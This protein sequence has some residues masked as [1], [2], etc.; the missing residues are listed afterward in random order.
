ME[1]SLR[2]MKKDD[3]SAVHEMM[4]GLH[5]L[6]VENR[7]DVFRD[8]DPLERQTF[9]ALLDNR[10]IFLIL[11]EADGRAAGF[12]VVAMKGPSEAPPPRTP[13]KVAVMDDLYVHGDFR[14]SGV[15]KRLFEE[16][17]REARLRG[18]SSLELSVWAFNE[19]ARG[20]YR[21]VGM[22]ERSLVME[23]EL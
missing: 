22:S 16:A 2:R 11:A 9:D 13:R 19:T 7:P 4:R 12:C 23:Y 1:I 18:A 21:G 20:F 15:G 6:H 8:A 14:K 5:G 17:A 10:D 3:F